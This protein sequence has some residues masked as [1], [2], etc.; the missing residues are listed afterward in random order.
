MG[1]GGQKAYLPPEEV[2]MKRTPARAAEITI[3][4]GRGRL[5]HGPG[6]QTLCQ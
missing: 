2:A 6:F 4:T 5:G 1:V 3:E